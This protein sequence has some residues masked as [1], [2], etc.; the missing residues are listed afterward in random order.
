MCAVL[1]S[2]RQRRRGG[3][4]LADC[5]RAGLRGSG[6][7]WCP[8][9]RAQEPAKRDPER[10]A[11]EFGVGTREGVELLEW[12]RDEALRRRTAQF[13]ITRT[14]L[15]AQLQRA[16]IAQPERAYDRL[17]LVPRGSWDER[18]PVGATSRDWYPWRYNRRLSVLRRPFVQLSAEQDSDV[19]VSPTRLEQT[20]AYLAQT[21][22]GD[23]P[24]SMF[25][26]TNMKQ[27]IGRMAHEHGHRFAETVAAKCRANGWR[28]RLELP[29]TAVR[30]DAKLGDIDVLAWN[31][32]TGVV[33]MIECKRLRKDKTVG[34]VGERLHEFAV[35]PSSDEVSALGKHLRRLAYLRSDG[36]K[37]VAQL[38]RIPQQKLRIQ[39]GLV[40]DTAT[41]MAFDNACRKTLGLVA[42]VAAL[43]R[44][45]KRVNKM[46]RERRI[47]LR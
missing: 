44:R 15:L 17:S 32:G 23:L 12:L 8:I 29:M 1:D 4:L 5:R 28:V 10:T 36:R 46:K 26:S 47:G 3:G 6:R 38:T 30:G 22:T 40:T 27:Y 16:G 24:G 21:R 33:V 13:W 45:L 20:L 39:G 42:D 11:R 18:K 35:E 31:P 2:R 41:P 14:D 43:E 25:D 19:L 7:L 9:F 37:Y 34:E